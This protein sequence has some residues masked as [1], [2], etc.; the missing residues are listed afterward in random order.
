MDQSM[1]N[2]Q[3]LQAAGLDIGEKKEKKELL[4]SKVQALVASYEEEKRRNEELEQELER[5]KNA[6]PGTPTPREVSS[7]SNP[8][9]ARQPEQ[10]LPAAAPIAPPAAQYAPVPQSYAQP[11][12]SQSQPQSQ[13]ILPQPQQGV[14]ATGYTLQNFAQ[15]P[16]QQ[17]IAPQ[18]IAPQQSYAPQSAAPQQNP[19]AT[20]PQQ[21]VPPAYA[22]AEPFQPRPAYAYA[23]PAEE[24]YSAPPKPTVPPCVT[25]AEYAPRY[26]EPKYPE[27]RYAEPKYPEPRYAEPK[28]PE[29]RYAEPKYPEPRYAEPKYAEPRY[30]EPK[31]PEPRYAE[32]KYAEQ[33]YAEPKY[34]E[35]RYAEPKYAEPRY[36]EPKAPAYRE[37]SGE[38]TDA[39]LY[40]M[41]RVIRRIE[42]VRA[43]L[44]NGY[45][46]GQPQ[47]S[48]LDPATADLLDQLYDELG[49]LNR[50]LSH[51]RTSF[52]W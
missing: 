9:Y 21:P 50:D 40:S 2:Q 18:N 34:P 8:A 32:P 51:L 17:G 36:A 13:Q 7:Y 48:G 22:A 41:S 19:Y 33:R 47:P 25:A 38:S 42:Q 52:R 10:P 30:A 6:Q 12:Q 28:Y 4:R 3:D 15:Q 23:P 35:P 26:A 29:P 5:L 14:S 24:R 37:Q 45:G 46:Y 20:Y 11:Q 1:E 39:V 16:A 31:Y 44:H 27:P 43:R 49:D